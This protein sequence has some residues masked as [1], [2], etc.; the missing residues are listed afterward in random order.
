VGGYRRVVPRQASF[1]PESFEPPRALVTPDLVLE[2]LG[3][4]HRAADHAARALSLEHIRATP[5]FAGRSWP[6]E[7]SSAENLHDLEL[8]AR[9]FAVADS[10]RA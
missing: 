9:D 7:M 3:P 8:H 6:Y 5:G 4:Q 1:V 10:P 2:P